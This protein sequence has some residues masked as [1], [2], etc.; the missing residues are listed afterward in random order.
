MRKENRKSKTTIRQLTVVADEF[1]A[2]AQPAKSSNSI[3]ALD[4]I[5]M[6]DFLLSLSSSFFG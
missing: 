1:M 5:F 3:P 4:K 6:L 2:L